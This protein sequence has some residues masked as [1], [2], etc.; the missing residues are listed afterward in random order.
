MKAWMAAAMAGIGIWA[1]ACTASTTVPG[2]TG[3]TACS[4]LSTCCSS[5]SLP[6]EE[7]T[8]CAEVVTADI[9]IDCQSTLTGYQDAMYCSGGSGTGS[10]SSSTSSTSGGG[11]CS[12]L[13][14]CC[15]SLP[16]G[17]TTSCNEL[18]TLGVAADCSSALTAF[19]EEGLCN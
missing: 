7:Q 10:G 13:S 18:V 6:T 14:S 17:D 16:A 19:M 4:E 3:G 11:G 8:A 15:G 9:T 1:A 2:G 5:K 12:A